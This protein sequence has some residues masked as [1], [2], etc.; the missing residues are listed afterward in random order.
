MSEVGMYM[1]CCD[2]C[3]DGCTGEFF[4]HVLPCPLCDGG[5]DE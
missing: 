1:N 3:E 4:G 5:Y 2:H